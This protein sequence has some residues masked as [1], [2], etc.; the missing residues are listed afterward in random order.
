M[1]STMRKLRRAVAL[2]GLVGAGAFVLPLAATAAPAPVMT[3]LLPESSTSGV[4]TS[5]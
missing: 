5:W 2:L 4:G 3:G 1:T